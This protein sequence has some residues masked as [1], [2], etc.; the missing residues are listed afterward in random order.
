MNGWRNWQLARWNER[1]LDH[2]FRKRD[3]AD[4]PIVVLLA[5]P[6]ELARATGDPGAAPPDVRNAFVSAVLTAIRRSRSLLE[7]ASD[8]QLWPAPPLDDTIPRFVSHLVF[9]CIA[10]SESTEDLADEESFV[11]R[12]RE[13]TEDQLPEN[14]LQFLPRLWE[15]LRAW[16]SSGTNPTRYRRLI[17]PNP[18][19]L[20]R[21][22]YTV[23]LAFPDRRDQRQLSEL[24]DVAGLRGHEPPVGKVVSLVSSSR[25]R[26]RRSFLA[27]FDEFR[28][29]FEAA[30][31]RSSP[32]LAEH[33]FWAAVRDAALRGRGADDVPDLQ[34]RVQLLCEEQDD[35]LTV[36]VVADEMLPEA[37]SVVR[38][39]ELPVPYGQWR[40]ALLI[41]DD[42]T[43]DATSLA[44]VA[45]SLL[46]RRLRIPRIS[47]LIEQG[48]L[49]L[50][51]GQHG[52]L[53]LASQNSLE[54]ATVV[55]ARRELADDVVALFGRSTSSVGPSTYEGWLQIRD[56]RLRTLPSEQLE[57][58]AL[59]RCWMFHESIAPTSIR[60][61]GGV[62]ADDGWL[63][64]REVLP[65]IVV[66][67]KVVVSIEGEDGTH[68]LVSTGDRT[69][70]LPDRDLAGD[71]SI[72]AIGEGITD[73]RSIRFYTTPATEQYR[74]PPDRDA[75]IVEGLGGTATLSTDSRFE[76]SSRQPDAGALVERVVYLGPVVGQFVSDPEAAAW[77][78]TRFAGRTLAARC[79][80]DL[81]A[82]PPTARAASASAR[83]KWRKLLL[84]SAPDPSDPGF[85]GVRRSVRVQVLADLPRIE[86]LDCGAAFE[87]RTFPKP[88]PEVLRLTTVLAGRA[89]ARAGLSWRDWSA[90][91]Q[92]FLGVDAER[93]DVVTRAW[94]D[95]AIIDLASYARWRHRS[96][97]A[98]PPTLVAYRVGSEIGATLVGL[99]L[100]TTREA[101][102][103]AA[104][105]AGLP[106]EER[107]SVSELVPAS[108]TL[109]FPSVEQMMVLSRETAVSPLWLDI[110]F[111]DY[112]QAC[113]HEGFN[114][115]PSNYETRRRWPTWSLR[116]DVS[117]TVTLDQCMR[118]DRPDYWIVDANGRSV[119][120]YELNV[121]RSW[122]A[123]LAGEA[124]I[125]AVGETEIEAQHAYLPVPLA[126]VVTVLGAALPGPDADS[127]W[128]YRY[129]FSSRQLR[130]RVLHTMRRTF[131]PG[132]VPPQ[133]AQ[134]SG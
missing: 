8:Y 42:T 133:A 11:L 21:I 96:V 20:T 48:V 24:L 97:F 125:R 86:V 68:Q 79:R 85:E 100:P 93:V 54:L 117:A 39:V 130:D 30:A 105:R 112:G 90:L 88:L 75:W 43:I 70:K 62:C 76:P 41:G 109:R 64:F 114:P 57:S 108:V 92:R 36:F 120:S 65:Q 129:F 116:S 2:F 52:L 69:W 101:I 94:A 25:A 9:T 60:L 118:S 16:L 47:A 33:R 83:S 58:T 29:L 119:W 6:D 132:R 71:F 124:P 46:A 22:G 111:E 31:T 81:A 113:R 3:D 15:N 7:D 98:R 44:S 74:S 80:Q 110:A 115:P 38:A 66:P 121:A 51:E 1:L 23:K 73:R 55:L 56:V 17:L 104:E 122:A 127:A 26:F 19:G 82:V 37:G 27:A 106:I 35:R 45:R 28:K 18:G 50:V 126:R 91:V 34:V 53:E 123:T 40:Y 5:T 134:T 84:H 32:R 78:V 61:V 4:S 107:F 89:S 49:P 10:A 87:N 13:L 128:A 95:S 131:D 99:T 102:V 67:E 63:G 72:L 14:S 77:R 103:R 59:R 12:L